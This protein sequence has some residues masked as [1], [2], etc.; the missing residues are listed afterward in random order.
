MNDILG[1]AHLITQ[2]P[3]G[4]GANTAWTP[5]AGANWQCVDEIPPND[6]DYVSTP[7]LNAQDNYTFPA[8]AAGTYTIYAMLVS[9]R[10]QK[11]DASACS[12]AAENVLGGVYATGAS[13]AQ[14]TTLTHYGTVFPLD[15]NSVAWTTAN[16]NACTTGQKRTV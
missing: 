10:S 9:L 7:T 12:I 16:F 15:P 5:S 11:T 3:N 2:V 1:D 14:S 4:A 13:N 8:L 6:A